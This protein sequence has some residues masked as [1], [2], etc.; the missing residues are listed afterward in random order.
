MAASDLL[1][2]ALGKKAL[3]K[4]VV[5]GYSGQDKIEEVNLVNDKLVDEIR[6]KKEGRYLV[7]RDAFVKL[8]SA[9]DRK[10]DEIKALMND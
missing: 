9:Y 8:A 4:G 7:A 2:D 10:S 5:K 6:V 1:S 3:T